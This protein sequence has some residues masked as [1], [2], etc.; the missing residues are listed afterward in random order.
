ML[1]SFNCEVYNSIKCARVIMHVAISTVVPP[2]KRHRTRGES[3]IYG[4]A[5]SGNRYVV[6][7]GNVPRT[8]GHLR[9]WNT[10]LS[11]FWSEGPL[12]LRNV[13]SFRWLPIGRRLLIVLFCF[14]LVPV[15]PSSITLRWKVPNGAS[16]WP[17]AGV[18]IHE[19]VVRVN[20]SLLRITSLVMWLVKNKQL[21]N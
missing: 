5:I 11:V 20:A 10:F 21:L 13:D 19:Y 7:D 12:Y 4:H 3:G 14:C 1:A 6:Y 2:M 15:Y 17:L 9:F 8:K 18:R 16:F